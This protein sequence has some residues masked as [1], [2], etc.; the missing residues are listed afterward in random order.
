MNLQFQQL[1]N[2]KLEL[3]RKLYILPN[4]KSI[5]CLKRKQASGDYS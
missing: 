2:M 1:L 4:L 3:H 5:Y